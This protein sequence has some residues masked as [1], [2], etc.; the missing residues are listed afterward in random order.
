MDL[1]VI[2]SLIAM[3]A[4]VVSTV[5]AVVQVRKCDAIKNEIYNIKKET[6]NLVKRSEESATINNTGQNTGVM[7][8][9]VKGGVRIGK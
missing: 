7:S 5:I 4:T 2:I 3:V 6:Y 8:N 9:E 1:N